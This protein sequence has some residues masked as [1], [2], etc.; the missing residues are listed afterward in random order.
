[1]PRCTA[2][3]AERA[4]HLFRVE[5]GYE[6]NRNPP[7]PLEEWLADGPDRFIHLGEEYVQTGRPGCV[8]ELNGQVASVFLE[9]VGHLDISIGG[10]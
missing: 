4:L 1:M 10:L 8:V 9:D 7:W 6:E 5:Q 3:D 2:R